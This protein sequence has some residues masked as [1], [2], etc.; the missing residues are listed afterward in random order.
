MVQFCRFLL[1]QAEPCESGHLA[2]N[3]F[4]TYQEIACYLGMHSVTIA[5]MV[6]SLRAEEMIRKNWP[7]DYKLLNPEQMAKLITEERK[8]DY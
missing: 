1:D 6:K 2:L 8:I 3:T 4:F 5:R 7:S